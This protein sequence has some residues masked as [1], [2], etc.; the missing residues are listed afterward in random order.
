MFKII[1]FN[2]ASIPGLPNAVSEL[3]D[4]WSSAYSVIVIAQATKSYHNS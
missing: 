2:V 1:L 3:S 4:E